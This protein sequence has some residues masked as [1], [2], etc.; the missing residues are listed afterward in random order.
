MLT[1]LLK[2][3]KRDE[4][5]TQLFDKNENYSKYYVGKGRSLQKTL[6]AMLNQTLYERQDSHSKYSIVIKK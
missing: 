5:I 6:I 1:S 3:V 4:T 2:E